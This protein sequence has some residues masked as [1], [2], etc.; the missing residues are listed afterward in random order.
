MTVLTS[1]VGGAN[2]CMLQSDSKI[3]VVGQGGNFDFATARC[4][5]NGVLDPTFGGGTGYVVTQFPNIP[6]YTP[7]AVPTAVATQFGNDTIQNPDRIVV[8][9]WAEHGTAANLIAIARYNMDGTPDSIFR[10]G[11]QNDE[12][13]S[14]RHLGRLSAGNARPGFLHSAAQDRHRRQ[15]FLQRQICHVDGSLQLERHL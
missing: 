11:R 13:H 8:S 14:P 3:V 15:K 6:N 2:A 5:T 1:F 7:W 10:H 12:F 4:T 9:G